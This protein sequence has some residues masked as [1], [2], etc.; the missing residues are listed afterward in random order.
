M[1][2]LK[3]H[4]LPRILRM[5]IPAS[6]KGKISAGLHGYRRK[7]G[8]NKTRLHL[9]IDPDGAGTLVINASSILHL[10]QTASLI[11]YHH[12]N[13]NDREFIQRTL[14]QTFDMVPD[15]I[16]E[17]I[18]LIIS[19]LE[20]FIQADGK[21]VQTYS[22]VEIN[23]PYSHHPT[24]PYRMD[25]ALTYRCNNDCSHCYNA[26]LRSYPELSTGNWKNIIQRCWDLDIPHLI[27][28]GGEPTLR[29][30]LVE[31]IAF[32]ESTGQITGLNTNGRR[33]S[34]PS[35]VQSL[36][37]AGLD[38]VQIT[39]ESHDEDI[40]D[41]MVNLKGAWKQTITGVKNALDSSLYVMTN[42]TMLKNN[43]DSMGE[44]LDF[45]ADLGVPTVGLNALIYAGRG[46]DVGTGLTE[47]EL[48]PLLNMAQERTTHHDQKLIW[49]TPTLYCHFNPL[50]MDLGIKGCTAALYNMCVEPDGGVLPCQSYYQQLGN[51]LTDSWS[52]IWEHDLSLSLRE[53]AYVP[54]EC[55]TCSLLEEC[56]SGCPLAYAENP[57]ILH[58]LIPP[59]S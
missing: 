2:K 38:H 28:T 46:K 39:V 45:L 23:A 29:D 13:G 54:G 8:K 51:L 59:P 57:R 5:L 11:A 30:D 16:E 1:T 55:Q 50:E 22:G 32:A 53:R 17:Q 6:N 10:N 27:F 20:G 34:D 3:S 43:Q 42:T 36:V 35:Y 37:K 14:V 47:G 41:Q 19:D 18:D 40:H 52:S 25:L 58:P 24:A 48:K 12:L 33:L 31:L 9:R 56:G 44:T 15:R 21:P 49:Y 4:G 7:D 26:R